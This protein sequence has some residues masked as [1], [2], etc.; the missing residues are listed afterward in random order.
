MVQAKLQPLR[1]MFPPPN[2]A[3]DTPADS[4]IM[5]RHPQCPHMHHQHTQQPPPQPLYAGQSGQGG[6]VDMDSSSMQGSS[7][8]CTDFDSK[9]QQQGEHAGSA[10]A[11]PK[12]KAWAKR[13]FRSFR[14]KHPN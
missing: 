9:E 8:I 13:M 4:T 1:D 11:Q 6:S 3:S 14:G 2:A 12:V 5:V 7:S 10:A